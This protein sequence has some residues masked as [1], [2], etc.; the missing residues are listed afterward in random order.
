MFV[1]A[2]EHCLDVRLLLVLLETI[3]THEELLDVVF[4]HP[5]LLALSQQG[6]QVVV[7]DELEAGEVRALLLQLGEQALLDLVQFLDLDGQV[8]LF[9]DVERLQHEFLVRELLHL[10]GELGVDAVEGVLLFLEVLAELVVALHE[11]AVELQPQPLDL[12]VEGEHHLQRAQVVVPDLHAVLDVSLE[13][14]VLQRFERVLVLFD[15]VEDLLLLLD[16]GD[17]FVEFEF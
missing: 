13:F 4:H 3:H 15:E 16:Q 1:L 17:V 5:E 8:L 12:H 6:D 14:G 2:G 7:P 10:G 11:D 9:E